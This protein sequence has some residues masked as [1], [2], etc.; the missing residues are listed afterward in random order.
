MIHVRG[1]IK[2][3][4]LQMSFKNYSKYSGQSKK[5]KHEEMVAKNEETVQA[6]ADEI[7]EEI[8]N[9]KVEEIV[10]GFV[11]GCTKLNVRSEANKDS[12]ILCVINEKAEVLVHVVENDSGDFYKVRTSS[13]IEGYCMKKYITIK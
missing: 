4:G 6:V 8:V 3:G 11:S 9:P 12:K 7:I 13:G 1:D 2:E 5:S 10:D